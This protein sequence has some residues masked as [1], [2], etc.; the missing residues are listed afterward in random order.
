[1]LNIYTNIL[2]RYKYQIYLYK[3][4]KYCISRRGI[5]V[6]R[7]TLNIL[8]PKLDWLL[9]VE[10]GF[11]VGLGRTLHDS[12]TGGVPRC[13]GGH[14]NKNLVLPQIQMALIHTNQS[15]TPCLP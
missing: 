12:L 9:T 5:N 3:K 8:T 2:H 6:D 10:Y 15:K 11:M 7:A 4:H 1:M 14:T 13:P